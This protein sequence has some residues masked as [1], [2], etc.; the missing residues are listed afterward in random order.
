VF[1][2]GGEV[3]ADE[4][5]NNVYEKPCFIISAPLPTLPTYTSQI[6]VTNSYSAHI[7]NINHP[8]IS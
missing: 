3:M 7:I 4:I 1:G 5:H 6:A 8:A 2:F